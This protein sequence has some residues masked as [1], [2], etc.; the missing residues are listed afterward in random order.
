VPDINRQS[1]SKR[2]YDRRWR[3]VRER[4][5]KQNPLCVDCLAEGIVTAADQ[6]HHMVKVKVDP[7]RRLDDT[8]LMSL[9]KRHHDK[10]TAA[11][12]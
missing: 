1:A 4:H 9:C 12:E 6:V 3:T 5:L 8:I 11:G 7:T 2:G 10:R